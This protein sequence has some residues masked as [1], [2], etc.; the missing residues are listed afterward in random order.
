MDSDAPIG[1]AQVADCVRLSNPR[2]DNIRN[3]PEYGG[4]PLYDIG[5]YAIISGILIFGGGPT[6][7]LLKW[8]WMTRMA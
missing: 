3:V 5:C 7:S 8:Q 2:H 4:G 1:R 6:A